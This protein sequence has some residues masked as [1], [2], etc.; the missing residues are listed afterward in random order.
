MLQSLSG[1]EDFLSKNQETSQMQLQYGQREG[2]LTPTWSA[3]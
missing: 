1:K 2:V 3:W